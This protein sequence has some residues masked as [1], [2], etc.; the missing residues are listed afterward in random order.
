MA[1]PKHLW[2]GDWERE[3]GA[4]VDPAPP[5]T[6]P[7]DE[8]APA[9]PWISTP[10][11]ARPVPPAHPDPPPPQA[12]VPPVLA[13]EPRPPRVTLL[14]RFS[15][16]SRRR[17]LA[18]GVIAAVIV[19]GVVALTSGGS[20][21]GSNGVPPMKNYSYELGL[22]LEGVPG[23][24]YVQAVVPGSPAAEHGIGADDPLLSVNGQQAQSPAQVNRILSHI[25]QGHRVTLRLDQGSVVITVQIQIT[26][27]ASGP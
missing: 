11:P 20:G 14:T 3:S 9:R 5:L 10:R 4:D 17:A 24:V 23:G 13:P 21:S 7:R 8:P 15:A 1:S 25:P 26:G 6:P 18:I 12:Q 16:I 27:S 19:V 22:V 2:S